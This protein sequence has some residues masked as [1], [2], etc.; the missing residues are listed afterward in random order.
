MN[1]DDTN[2]AA[3]LLAIALKYKA[4]TDKAPKIVAKGRKKLAY[5]IIRVAQENGV[6]IKQDKELSSILSLLEIDEY[7]P[8]EA[9]LAVAEIMS[10]IYSKDAERFNDGAK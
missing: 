10:Y 6:L 9:F 7:I 8:C 4:E 1:N 3:D 5:E 2:K